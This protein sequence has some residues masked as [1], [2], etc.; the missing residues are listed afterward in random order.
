MLEDLGGRMSAWD[1]STTAEDFQNCQSPASLRRLG[2]EWP[3][4]SEYLYCLHVC[5]LSIPPLQD[6]VIPSHVGFDTR[7]SASLFNDRLGCA[8][9][10]HPRMG[11]ITI[12]S[13]VHVDETFAIDQ[14]REPTPLP[15]LAFLFKDTDGMRTI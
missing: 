14:T 15:I 6:T 1:T 8:V 13:V 10:P 9:D 7:Y 11:R 4:P 12:L 2:Q 3:Y 5:G